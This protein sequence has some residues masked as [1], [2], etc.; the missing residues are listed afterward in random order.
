MMSSDWLIKGVLFYHFLVFFPLTPHHRG[1]CPLEFRI[2]SIQ[3]NYI[4]V[5]VN[6]VHVIF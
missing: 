6:V 3:L 5:L 4:N 1:I 2:E